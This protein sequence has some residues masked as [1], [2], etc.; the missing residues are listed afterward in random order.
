[1]ASE[2]RIIR[3]VRLD[4]QAMRRRID[5][6]LKRAGGRIGVAAVALGID[7][8]TLRRWLRAND[9]GPKSGWPKPSRKGAR[10]KP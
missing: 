7:V 8:R 5:R 2:F 10:A 4:P 9:I 1:M 3:R 6:A